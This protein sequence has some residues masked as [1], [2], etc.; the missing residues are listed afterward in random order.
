M[1]TALAISPLTTK[2]LPSLAAE[3]SASP[4][5]PGGSP[6]LDPLVIGEW[7]DMPVLQTQL[8]RSRIQT[9]D[10]P[11]LSPNLNPLADQELYYDPFLFGAWE[12]TAT[13]KRK[14]FPFGSSFLPSS[15]IDGSPR[16]D[17]ET[18]GSNCTYELHFFSTLANT[19]S[20]QITV[21]LGTGVPKSKIIQD[22]SYNLQ[23]VAKAYGQ[24]TPQQ[25]NWD[26]RNEPTRV[27][28][29]YGVPVAD[30]MRPLGRR[31]GELYI[32]GRASS[33]SSDGSF[34]MT[35]QVRGVLV[36]SG[37]GVVSDSETITEFHPISNDHVVAVL[38][39]AVFLSPNPNSREGL[40][41]QQVGGR[42]VGL[43]DYQLD[44]RRINEEFRL[45]DGSI[46]KRSCVKTPKD[47][48]QCE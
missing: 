7:D 46:N 8:G 11:S 21:N 22:R 29:D 43:Y 13:L 35:E 33:T 18:V 20:N 23:S 27:T 37:L 1:G 17:R 19:L 48:V 3:V 2:P 41:W 5:R 6:T 15:L 28:I 25:V 47:F 14:T 4:W 40:L 32:T 42:A 31:R 26:Y 36:G 39:I 24:T 44:L 30:D 45:A 12:T 38:R 9:F 16:A 10:L 34:G